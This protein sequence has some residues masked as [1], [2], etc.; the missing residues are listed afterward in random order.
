MDSGYFAP[1]AQLHRLDLAD[2]HRVLLISVVSLD[3]AT[4]VSTDPDIQVT[5]TSYG[6]SIT[7]GS[8]VM[9][10]YSTQPTDLLEGKARLTVRLEDVHYRVD[11]DGNEI[12]TAPPYRLEVIDFLNTVHLEVSDI[13]QG[14]NAL[15]KERHA[16]D[17][18]GQIS[19]FERYVDGA[20]QSI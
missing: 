14:A 7:A 17:H 16:H 4:F 18:S 8:I 2:K 1:I 20:W 13:V 15:F 3:Y 5:S 19:H 11:R 12:R 9:R 6:G 10:A